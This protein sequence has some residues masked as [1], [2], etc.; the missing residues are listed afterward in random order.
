MGL[1]PQILL[2]DDKEENLFA[3]EQILED[4]DV[5]FALATSGNEA[6]IKAFGEQY[7]LILMDVQ[8]PDMDG[9]EA[10]KLI[11]KDGKNRHTPVIFISAIY[12]DDFYKLKGLDSGGIDFIVKPVVEAFLIGKVKM[13]LK[14]YNHTK[15]LLELSLIDEL[16]GLYNRR[17]FT[18]LVENRLK[19]ELRKKTECTLLFLDL[20]GLKL[21]NDTL[22]HIEGDRAIK[23]I[24]RILQESFRGSDILARLGG[25]E[26]AVFPIESKSDS[27]EII[28]N[29]I[30]NNIAS[31]NES[32][33]HKFNL[34]ASIGIAHS[35]PG[36]P[37]IL[38]ELIDQADSL[39]YKDK[40]KKKKQI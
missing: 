8:M 9:F 27:D 31:F 24:S 21:I 32:N 28:I 17:G 14:L 12:S 6:V 15:T 36:K 2:V 38:S 25:D 19:I 35:N 4:L 10:V 7:A 37:V 3:I 29:R 26:F 33:S 34:S 39:M 16:T 1:R 23:S 5:D 11:Q 18:T 13:F 30:Q 22:G 40:L 20:D